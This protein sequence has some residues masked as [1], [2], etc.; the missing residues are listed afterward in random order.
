MQ[1]LTVVFGK[2]AYLISFSTCA[3]FSFIGF[4]FAAFACHSNVSSAAIT[5]N[6]LKEMFTVALSKRE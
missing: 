5:A 3:G 4:A 6:L 1:L 2:I